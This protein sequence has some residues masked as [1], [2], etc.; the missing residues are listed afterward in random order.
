MRSR[1]EGPGNEATTEANAPPPVP[2]VGRLPVAA[3]APLPALIVQAGP[4]AGFAWDEF[5]AARLRNH[6]TRT[7]YVRA[8]RQ[9]LDWAAPKVASLPE[10]T[11]GMVGAYFDQHSG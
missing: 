8:V 6:H 10:I 3:A 11:A 5:F 9:F 7:A 4:A 2:A 1:R